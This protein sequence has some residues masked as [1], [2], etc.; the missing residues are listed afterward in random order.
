M[1]NV[2]TTVQFISI[3]WHFWTKWLLRDLPKLMQ[4]TYAICAFWSSMQSCWLCLANQKILM[5]K[6]VA[7]NNETVSVPPS[8]PPPASPLSYYISFALSEGLDPPRFVPML[9]Q[10][11]ELAAVIRR[12]VGYRFD[13][14]NI[15]HCRHGNIFISLHEEGG[16]APG[17]HHLLCPDRGMPIIPSFPH[18]HD[19]SLE[20]F[21]SILSKE[22]GR[23]SYLYVF[24]EVTKEAGKTM[25]RIYM[26]QDGVWR[27]LTLVTCQ[28]PPLWLDPK[29]P[30]R[31]EE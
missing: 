23:S 22:E 2:A 19:R 26:L 29:D 25:T 5:R 7:L 8:F 17:V 30:T 11:P 14:Q 27:M 24:G 1:P 21:R 3:C 4:W 16:L 18:F 10:P 15:M 13:A 12:V 31:N 9:P 20:N 6:S 28:L